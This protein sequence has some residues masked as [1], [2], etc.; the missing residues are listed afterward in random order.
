M[1][2]EIEIIYENEDI[3]VVNKTSGI[4]AIAQCS[5]NEA[6]TVLGI[7]SKQIAQK[8]LP[9]HSL[10]VD[11]SGSVVFAKNEKSYKHIIEQFKNK[12]VVKKYIALLSGCVQDDNGEINKPLLVLKDDVSIDITGQEAITKFKVLER[13]K[14]YTLVEAFPITSVKRQL[15][16]HF[17]SMGNPLAVDAQY[18]VNEPI[19][20]SSLKRRYKPKKWQQERPL[21]SRLTLHLE[22]LTLKIP[23]TNEEKKFKTL[24]PKDFE[25]TLKKLEKYGR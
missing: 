21:I 7:L 5:V 16:L 19:L 25:I 1:K 15:R 8:I 24:L 6:K 23:D 12:T 22:S 13:F 14:S 2:Q 18:G 20:L 17:W 11:V 9:I 3:I 10:D 4:Y